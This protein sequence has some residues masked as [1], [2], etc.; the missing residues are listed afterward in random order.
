M[1]CLGTHRE[2]PVI[3]K[4]RRAYTNFEQKTLLINMP[5]RLQDTQEATQCSYAYH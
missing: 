2:D 4:T 1:R 3:L 5:V